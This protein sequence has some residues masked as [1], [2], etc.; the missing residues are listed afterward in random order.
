MKSN[1]QNIKD[2][3]CQ[4]TSKWEDAKKVNGRTLRRWAESRKDPLQ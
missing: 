1:G 2:Y 3:N 4:H